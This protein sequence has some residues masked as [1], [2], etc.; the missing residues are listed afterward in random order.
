[1][2]KTTLNPYVRIAMVLMVAP[3]GLLAQSSVKQ[4]IKRDVP[5]GWHLMDQK[6]DGYYGIALDKAYELLK[7]K[8]SKTVVKTSNPFSG[9]IQTK[10]PVMV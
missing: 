3:L 6:K 4:E 8:K 7:G 2:I 5:K 1:M 9:T 10:F